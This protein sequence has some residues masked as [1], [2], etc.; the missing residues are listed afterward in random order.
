MKADLTALF[1]L[2]MIS[3]VTLAQ[4]AAIVPYRYTINRPVSASDARKRYQETLQKINAIQTAA[5]TNHPNSPSK[6]EPFECP[7]LD[8]SIR[9]CVDDSQ[10][11]YYLGEYLPY[12]TNSPA[13]VPTSD[14]SSM[15]EGGAAVPGWVPMEQVIEGQAVLKRLQDMLENKTLD[16]CNEETGE[17]KTVVEAVPVNKEERVL[18][19]CDVPRVE[20]ETGAVRNC[21]AVAIVT[22]DASYLR[23]VVAYKVRQAATLKT[24]E[25]QA[26]IEYRIEKGSEDAPMPSLKSVLGAVQAALETPKMKLKTELLP[27]GNPVRAIGV[28]G[29]RSNPKLGSLREKVSFKV[30]VDESASG[31]FLIKAYFNLQVNE[32]HLDRPEDFRPP[33]EIE[34]G[35]YDVS[36]HLGLKPRLLHLCKPIIEPDLRSIACLS[37]PK[38]PKRPQPS[39]R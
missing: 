15:L 5:G 14:S 28:A 31:E 17:C 8:G 27:K 21:V 2:T 12:V 25:W 22:P 33:T 4:Q 34:V 35:T 29:L 11:R 38:I 24:D 37:Y 6:Y 18:A 20:D 16:D 39:G 9:K 32:Q 7:G 1:L 10:V 3:S 26:V 13:L 23:A 30:A 36:F 19:A